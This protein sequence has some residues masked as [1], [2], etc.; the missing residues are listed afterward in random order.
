MNI[1]PI[2][3]RGVKTPIEIDEALSV[4]RACDLEMLVKGNYWP[5]L[6][7]PLLIGEPR[8]S[9]TTAV[10]HHKNVDAVYPRSQKIR[11]CP[12]GI[13]GGG[14]YLPMQMNPLRILWSKRFCRFMQK[15]CDLRAAARAQHKCARPGG[16]RPADRAVA[17]LSILGFRPGRGGG[18]VSY[19]LRI[20]DQRLS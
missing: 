4:E 3:C 17:T 2:F 13:A 12:F 20:A 10:W 15:P 8:N 5:T 11:G 18:S 6:T 7:A 9:R 19:P 1:T 16:I 14:P